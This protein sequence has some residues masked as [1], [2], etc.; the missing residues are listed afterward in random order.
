MQGRMEPGAM[1]GT[2]GGTI[3]A[4]CI[5]C[6]RHNSSLRGGRITIA[7]LMQRELEACCRRGRAEGGGYH[8]CGSTDKEMPA[9]AEIIPSRGRAARR[10]FMANSVTQ[11]PATGPG[12]AMSHAKAKAPERLPYCDM[13]ALAAARC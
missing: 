1:S 9:A 4:N 8:M 7:L 11:R 10:A 13:S 12:R 2:V 3:E 6:V 5:T